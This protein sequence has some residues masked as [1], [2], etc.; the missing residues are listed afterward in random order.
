[1]IPC[2]NILIVGAAGRDAGK[3]E[4][5][6]ELIRRHAARQFVVAVKI[7]TIK[8]REGSCPRGGQGCGVCGSLRGPYCLTEETAAATGKDTARMKAAGARHVFWLRVLRRHLREGVAELLR[9]MPSKACVVCESNSARL[10]L[11]PGA[12]LVIREAGSTSTKASCAAVL[13]HADRILLFH[14]NHWDMPPDRCRFEAGRWIVPMQA[15]AAVLAGGQSRRMGRDKSLL[16][17]AGLTMLE[18]ILNQVRPLVDETLVGADNPEKYGFTGVRVIPD[19]EPGQ[20]PLMGILSCVQ[21][22]RRERVLVTACD[23]PELPTD[24]LRIMLRKA[25]RTDIV[26]PR[27]SCGRYEPLPAVYTRRMLPA[28]RAVLARGGRR[29]VEILDEPDVHAEFVRLPPGDWHRNLNTPDDYRR[30][31]EHDHP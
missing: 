21:A 6:G 18:H 22:A 11:N 23:I 17:I 20:G 28:A 26:M 14:G 1:M 5:I 9:R 3:T 24:F 8:E 16:P 31:V 7:T 15:S 30:T 25:N 13:E 12:F 29:V 2:P 4:F 10:V 19:E 27:D